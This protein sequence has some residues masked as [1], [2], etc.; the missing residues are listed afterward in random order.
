MTFM[1]P[2]CSQVEFPQ[3]KSWTPYRQKHKESRH[4]MDEEVVRRHWGKGDIPEKYTF[5]LLAVCRRGRKVLKGQFP[6]T[7]LSKSAD[8]CSKKVK[9]LVL[10]LV[11]V[12]K[13]SQTFG[14]EIILQYCSNI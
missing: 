8:R 14:P 11:C 10:S 1:W 4:D 9:I 2:L 5:F 13:F 6:S 3:G 12:Q 7:P